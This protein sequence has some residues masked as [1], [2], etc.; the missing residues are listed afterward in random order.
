MFFTIIFYTNMNGSNQSFSDQIQTSTFSG[1]MV[2]A[3]FGIMIIMV[4]DRII[5]STFSFERNEES[6]AWEEEMNK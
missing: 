1:R 3:L 4:I 2:L 5:Y 6:K